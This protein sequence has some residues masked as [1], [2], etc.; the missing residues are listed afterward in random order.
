MK[1]NRNYMIKKNGGI[2]DSIREETEGKKELRERN[3]EIL[4]GTCEGTAENA[5]HSE[6]MV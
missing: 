4:K 1:E 6:K 5:N 2:F 3:G